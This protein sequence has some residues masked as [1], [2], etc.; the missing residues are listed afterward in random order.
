[1]PLQAPYFASTIDVLKRFKLI[2]CRLKPAVISDKWSSYKE[3]IG[4]ATFM[5]EKVL[6]EVCW[7]KIDYILSFTEPIRDMTC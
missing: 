4:K 1:M 5:R 3:V 7:D 2:K 6:D